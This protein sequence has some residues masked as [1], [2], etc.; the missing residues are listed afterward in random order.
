MPLPCLLL[1]AAAAAA[2]GRPPPLPVGPL[3]F[4]SGFSNDAVLQRG[5]LGSAIYG[6]AQ[7]AAPVQVTVEGA[8]AGG[9]SVSYTVDAE[10]AP[11]HDT[12]GCNAT[13]P[14]KPMQA[15]GNWT[16]RAT[17]KPQPE[18]GGAY[19][20]LVRDSSSANSTISINRV[21]Y[22]DVYF[23]S[24]QSNMD[25]ELSFTFSVDEL[26]AE[27]R[28]GKYSEIRFFMYGYMNG[29]FQ[30]AA[31]Q[32]T[33]TWKSGGYSVAEGYLAPAA[34]NSWLNVTASSQ[35]PSYPE[36]ITSFGGHSDWSRFSATCMYFGVELI[37]ARKAQ[38]LEVDVPIGLIQSA[39]GGTEI[40]S[41][42][43]EET[44]AQCTDLSAN[45]GRSGQSLLYNGMVS[46]WVNYSVAGWVWYQGENDCSGVTGNVKDHTGYGCALP[47]MIKQWRQVWAPS[48]SY[49]STLHIDDQ[50]LFGVVTLAAGGSEGAGQHM[51]GLRWSQS[52]NYGRWPNPEMPW[53]FGAQAYGK[54][55]P[56]IACAG[57]QCTCSVR[58]GFVYSLG[59]VTASSL[60]LIQ[61]Y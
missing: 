55:Q 32:Y 24:G 25:L 50:R 41:W 8:T 16:W 29:V 7:S 38:G 56:P 54:Q 5:D 49:T 60:V 28:A 47:G 3:Q 31:P 13:T 43:S 4:S 34:G 22:G 14:T 9:K 19:T 2:S 17:L 11:W 46:P 39:V 53:S 35:K 6:F 1:C 20:V 18:A 12:S 10:V 30:A 33:A 52:A 26:Q 57:V 40:E 61:T 37:N 23:C 48:Y 44:R 21:T 15:H 45:G 58:L 51:A 36:G 42:M 59:F 27:M